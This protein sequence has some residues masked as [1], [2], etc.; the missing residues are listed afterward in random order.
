VH[1]V[2]NQIN[3]GVIINH[4]KT[5][6]NLTVTVNMRILQEIEKMKMANRYANRSQITEEILRDGFAARG[7]IIIE[8]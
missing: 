3:R 1:Q 7:I 8:S 4:T 5:K 6:E 2:Y